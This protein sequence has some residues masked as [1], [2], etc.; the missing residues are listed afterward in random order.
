MR[1]VPKYQMVCE[2]S[3]S[4]GRTSSAESDQAR[5][6]PGRNELRDENPTQVR[7]RAQFEPGH[8]GWLRREALTRLLTRAVGRA[9]Q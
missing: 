1:P 8:L 3:V 9:S 2:H 5:L 6:G 7:I 4:E